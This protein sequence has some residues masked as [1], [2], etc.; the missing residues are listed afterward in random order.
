MFHK[1]V[2]TTSNTK[3]TTTQQFKSVSS[4]GSRENC[5]YFHEF[6]LQVKEVETDPYYYVYGYEGTDVAAANVN[7]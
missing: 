4:V 6:H 3:A 1:L 2:A 7:F 5:R